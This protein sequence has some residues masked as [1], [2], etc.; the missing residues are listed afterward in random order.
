MTALI[1]SRQGKT[2]EEN[3]GEVEGRRGK[4]EESRFNGNALSLLPKPRELWRAADHD[5]PNGSRK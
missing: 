3:K 5:S 1:K 4:E 2:K